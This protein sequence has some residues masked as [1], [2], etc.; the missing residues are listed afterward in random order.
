LART[1]V[2]SDPS[3]ALVRMLKRGMVKPEDL[4]QG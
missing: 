3:A 2:Y 4:V 1:E